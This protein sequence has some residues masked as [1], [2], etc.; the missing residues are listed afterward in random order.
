MLLVYTHQITNR[1]RYTFNLIFKSVLGVDC[2]IT[3]DMVR[4]KQYEGPKISYTSSA[5]SNELF[6]KSDDLLFDKD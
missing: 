6:F 4:F 3:S 5:L 1:V 2:E